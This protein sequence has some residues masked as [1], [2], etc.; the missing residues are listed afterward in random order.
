LIEIH[1]LDKVSR[2]EFD[3]LEARVAEL[4][5]MSALLGEVGIEVLEDLIRAAK[6]SKMA[7]DASKDAS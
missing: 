6:C 1:K 4:E 5:E 3:A 7:K 2:E